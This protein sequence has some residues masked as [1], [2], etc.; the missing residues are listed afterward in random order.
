MKTLTDAAIPED[1]VEGPETLCPDWDGGGDSVANRPAGPS[2]VDS[3]G[4]WPI[5]EVR[6]SDSS[7]TPPLPLMK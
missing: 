3:V 7:L 6:G 2:E 1:A 5:A 4:L